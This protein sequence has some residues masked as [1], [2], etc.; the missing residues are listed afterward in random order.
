[1]IFEILILEA[2]MR[3]SIFGILFLTLSIFLPCPGWAASGLEGSWRGGGYVTPTSGERESVRCSV[4]YSRQARKIFSV[5][6]K[7]ATASATIVQT[8]EVLEVSGGRYVGDFYN[9]QYDVSGRIRIQL[10][11]NSQ[12]VT[13]SGSRGRGS[14]I[15]TK[16]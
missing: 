15:L 6:A 3:E 10:S 14:M 8:G 4:Q 16:R 2:A 5:S 11:G 1:M 13:F 9:S 7:C 12:T